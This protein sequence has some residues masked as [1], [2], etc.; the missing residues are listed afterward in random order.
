MGILFEVSYNFGILIAFSIISAFILQQ[1]K[2]NEK[3]MKVF[4]GLLFGM[5]AVIGMLNP[6]VLREGLIFDGRSVMISLAA[7]FYGPI[8]GIV[9]I[10][11]PSIVRIYQGGSG[12]VMGLNIILFSGI[13]G[14][15]F[16]Y[17]SKKLNKYISS[18]NVYLMGMIVHISM[19]ILTILLPKELI[20]HVLKEVSIP[21]LLVYPI[22]TLIM[23]RVLIYSKAFLKNQN[24]LKEKEEQI[25]TISNN[26]KDGLIYQVIAYP[27]GTKKFTYISENSKKLYG[28]SPEEIYKDPNLIYERLHP[29]FV[30]SLIKAEKDSIQN[31]KKFKMEV[32]IQN[33]DG[34][35][36][37]SSLVSAPSKM[38][39]GIIYF[40]G[41][42]FVITE[43]KELQLQ[44]EHAN[45]AKSEFLAN[46]SHEIRTPMNG[47]FGFT[48]LLQSMETDEEKLEY[49]RLIDFSAEHLLSIINDILNLAKIEAGKYISEAEKTNM[50][51]LMETISSIYKEQCEKKKIEFE[52][53]ID[54]GFSNEIMLDR[55]SLIQ[56]LNNLLSNAVKFTEFGK[57][58]CEIKKDEQNKKITL[59]IED[60]GIGINQEKMK[61]LYEPFEQGE[62]YLNKKYGGTGLGLTIVKSLVDLLNGKITVK[63]GIGAG[64]K[65]R[66]ELPFS[67]LPKDILQEHECKVEKY[68]GKEDT[69][70]ILADD[71]KLNHKIV[72]TMLEEVGYKLLTSVYNGKALLDELRK[73][74]YDVAL[75]DIQMPE[76]NGLEAI[77]QLKTEPDKNS[78]DLVIIAVSAF[79]LKNEIKNVLDAGADAYI[80]KPFHKQELLS[81]IEEKTFKK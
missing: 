8:A 29:D 32:M 47:I 31:Q 33:P 80:T 6:V 43:M 34:T 74:Q 61:K 52:F 75:V 44:L 26:L 73:K 10:I 42:E 81:I 27:D 21:V 59:I 7:M 36:R 28:H 56:I 60:T 12:L 78:I 22:A 3:L 55:K 20:L 41:I 58:I 38:Q 30:D 14:S 46:M 39:N 45:K 69:K 15:I 53:E 16:Y 57:I 70:I 62:L 11:F 37:W 64:T 18:W 54:K 77:R 67:E 9:S 51:E 13:I 1:K 23:G 25:R 4:Q 68:K 66:L 40:D 49:L 48:D 19:L 72:G 17:R 71:D 2:V 79:A 76:L 65:F 35:Y 50:H 5:A 63:T 24:I